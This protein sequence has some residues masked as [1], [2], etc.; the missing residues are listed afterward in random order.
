MVHEE[1]GVGIE[2]LARMFGGRIFGG[3]Q[4]RRRKLSVD[5]A[6]ADPHEPRMEGEVMMCWFLRR[7]GPIS[8]GL[9]DVIEDVKTGVLRDSHRALEKRCSVSVVPLEDA[10]GN[11][12][13]ADHSS[14]RVTPF[15]PSPRDDISRF[16][17]E[18]PQSRP[19]NFHP[20]LR[21]EGSLNIKLHPKASKNNS[22][23]ELDRGDGTSIR[24]PFSSFS[25]IKLLAPPAGMSSLGDETFTIPADNADEE[26]GYFGT[27]RKIIPHC[28]SLF[29]C[30]I[31]SLHQVD[32]RLL[33]IS[34][35]T[36]LDQTF[37]IESFNDEVDDD[38]GS[39]RI[40][41]NMAKR[42]DELDKALRRILVLEVELEKSNKAVSELRQA[43]SK[44]KLRCLDLER[45]IEEM[46]KVCES[47]FKLDDGYKRMLAI[48]TKD[49][50][51]AL[52]LV[53]EIRKLMVKN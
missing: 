14:G 21:D 7:W 29:L 48:A 22:Y 10:V 39:A 47:D 3:G 25:I 18:S 23:N 42:D 27:T 34:M 16:S 51:D 19:L 43:L 13:V 45:R 11:G 32:E 40:P 17:G 49:R 31:I 15:R 50:D 12:E 5:I 4:S 28:F 8:E 52:D 36:L 30:L 20:P 38:P 35:P 33:D 53:R 41:T 2:D 46:A 44:E 37:P 26:S 24:S 9:F 6:M 1:N